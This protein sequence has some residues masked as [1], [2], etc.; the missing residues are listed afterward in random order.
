M[1]GITLIG[2]GAIGGLVAAWLCQRGDLEVTVCVRTPIRK[3]KLESPYGIIEAHPQVLTSPSQAIPADWV[4]VATKAYDSTAAATWFTSLLDDKTRIA[5]IQNGVDHVER[6]SAWLAPQKILP[7]I[8][9]CPTQRTD[10]ETIHQRGPA[11][12]TV[13]DSALGAAFTNLFENTGITAT[14]DPDFLSVAWRKLCINAAGAVNALTLEPARIAHNRHAA[15]VMRKLVRET[16][17]V[18]QAEGAKLDENL[19]EEVVRLYQGMP[20]DSVNSLHA[21]R[22]AGRRMEVNLRNGVIVR[23]GRKHGIATPFN[24]MAVDLLESLDPG[25]V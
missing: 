5:I 18:G 20:A 9:D 15:S 22:L 10:A 16:I 17:A 21:D 19:A 2:P 3:L 11:T 12:M 23:L 13:P 7:V 6:F 8:I 25:S 4:L 1:P 14:T 24:E